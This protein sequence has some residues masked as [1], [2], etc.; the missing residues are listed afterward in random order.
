LFTDSRL[1][2]ST[3][4]RDS[5]EAPF[6]NDPDEYL[7]GIES[8]HNKLRILFGMNFWR[9]IAAFPCYLLAFNFVFYQYAF[10]LGI[11]GIPEYSKSACNNGTS[12]TESSI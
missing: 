11:A 4:F 10:L 1:T 8:V 6:F 3:F 12:D 7:H 2:N 5:G 9:A